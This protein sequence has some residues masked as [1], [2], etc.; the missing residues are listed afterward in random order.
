M[1]K[2]NPSALLS[3]AEHQ[4]HYNDTIHQAK[5]YTYSPTLLNKIIVFPG[6]QQAILI[7][8]VLFSNS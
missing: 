6:F 5:V 2:G 8:F 4:E 1:S 3:H 7:G